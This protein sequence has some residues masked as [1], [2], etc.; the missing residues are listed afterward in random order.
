MF[1]NVAYRATVYRTGG[2][3]FVQKKNN[4]MKIKPQLKEAMYSG[5]KRYGSSEADLN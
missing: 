5:I 2:N 1:P 4:V 3:C